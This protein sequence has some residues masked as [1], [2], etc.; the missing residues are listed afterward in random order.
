AQTLAGPTYNNCAAAPRFRWDVGWQTSLRNG[1]IIQEVQN[2]FNV[3][4][5]GGGAFGGAAF[6][7]PTQ[8]YWEAWRVNNAGVIT[9]SV[10]ALH[11][12]WQRWFPPASQGTWTMRGTTFTVATLPGAA[13][14]AAGGVADAGVLQSTVIHPGSDNLGLP[15]GSRRISG[16]WT[17]CGAVNT[18]VP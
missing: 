10:G 13:G 12:R 4:G 1:F 14:F 7:Q 9:P 16:R 17:C 11:D 18:H 5:C 15:A 6:I 8:R 3:Q 2:T